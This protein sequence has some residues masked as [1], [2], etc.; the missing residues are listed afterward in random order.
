MT[1]DARNAGAKPGASHLA[2]ALFALLL[3]LG[4]APGASMAAGKVHLQL[5]RPAVVRTLS[6][7]GDAAAGDLRLQLQSEMGSHELQL[8]PNHTLGV[9]ATRLA[10]RAQ[11]YRG[12]LPGQ[13]GS[14]VAMT[15]IGTRWTGLIFDGAHY[16]GV[17]SARSLAA[18]SSDAARAAPDSMLVFRM[19]DMT[20]DQGSFEGDIRMP[21][22]EALAQ[23]V[24]GELAQ[25]QTVEAVTAAATLATKRLAVALIADAELA[26]Q[27]G[28]AVDTNMLARLNIVDGIFS[29]Q[30]GVRLQSLSSTVMTAAT[31]PFTTTDSSALLD[32]LKNYRLGSPTQRSAGLSHLMTGR[33][34][35][36]RTI[37]IAY[38][39]GLCSNSFSASLSEARSSLQFDALVAAHEIGHVFGAPHDSETGSAC[40]ATPATFLMAPQLNQSS[41]F[42][43]CSLDQIAP[44]VTRASCLALAD[45][46]D[47]TI[48]APNEAAIPLGLPTDITVAVRSVGNAT[49][50]GASLRVSVPSTLT[51]PV[52]LLAASSDA[53]ACTIA[54]QV[55]DC[56]LGSIAP[57][58]SLNVTFR[59][60][61]AVAGAVSATLRVLAGNDGLASNNSRA[62][63]LNFAPGADMAADIT[64]DATT[65]TVGG[66]VNAL[67]TLDNR[68]PAALSDARFVITLP[69]NLA[70]QSHTVDG[71]TCVPVTLGLTCGPQAMASGATV[72][73]NLVLRG[74]VAGSFSFS[75]VA[76]SS[77]PEV[78]SSDNTVQ[79]TVQVNAV[80]VTNPGTSGGGGGSVPTG[81]LAL[82]AALAAVASRA[83]RQG[84]AVAAAK[85]FAR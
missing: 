67:L 59:V 54:G 6:P 21:T 84:A 76:S 34:L 8:T 28:A 64:L 75:A 78:Q 72:R 82:L 60:Q 30:V 40:E 71:I 53:G 27:D 18:I 65:I 35:D 42:S 19:A 13:P 70:L 10:S 39:G 12:T 50:T 20:L 56:P 58:S 5:A 32:E 44:V 52:A 41:T 29:N 1:T 81:A 23:G 16:F 68:G 48:D 15:R 43:Q 14:W 77:A 49:L 46:A 22:A 66:S 57:D 3:C 24:A 61:G 63:R 83:R 11:A 51:L 25:P 31:Q 62:L 2:G 36:G 79:R 85:Y 33:N 74:D 4:M 80:P 38:I 45:A 7:A 37:G 73:V 69:A 17:D 55:A 26:A 9:L 47:G